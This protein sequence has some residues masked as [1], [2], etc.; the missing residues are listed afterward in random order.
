M[1]LMVS[2]AH[3]GKRRCSRHCEELY[4]FADADAPPAI[5][6]IES[7]CLMHRPAR[8]DAAEILVLLHP[9]DRRSPRGTETWLVRRPIAGHLHLRRETVRDVARLARLIARA[10]V[11][12]VF[13][14]GGAR[15]LAHLGVWRALVERG[16][17]A[18]GGRHQHRLG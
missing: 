15:G 9:P 12:L 17:D 14:G 13:A 18:S 11:G 1:L 6:A 3:A 4:L 10:G 7:D 2:V 5:H 16:I 8:T